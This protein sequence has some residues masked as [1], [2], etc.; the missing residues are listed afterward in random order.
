VEGELIKSSPSLP[1][2]PV[3]HSAGSNFAGRLV[4]SERHDQPP[5]QLATPLC[6][7]SIARGDATSGSLVGI[8]IKLFLPSGATVVW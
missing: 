8:N 7:K 3:L 2:L 6:D 4:C 1:Y 5:D